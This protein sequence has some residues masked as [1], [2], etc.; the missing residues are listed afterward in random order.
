MQTEQFRPARVAMLL[1]PVGEHEPAALD[2]AAVDAA[3]SDA[4]ASD[5]TPADDTSS[6]CVR[7][8]RY[9]TNG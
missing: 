6:R 3:L 8:H 5:A 7:F 1:K 9:I 4:A 2:A